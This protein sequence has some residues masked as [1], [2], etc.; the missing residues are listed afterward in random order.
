MRRLVAAAL[1][2]LL[3]VSASG[4]GAPTGP[5]PA[6]LADDA[7]VAPAP[8]EL[9][10]WDVPWDDTRPR[11]PYVAPDGRVWFVGQ[12]GDYVGVLAPSNGEF[13]RYDLD[14]GTG[15]HNLIVDDDGIVWY[16][17]NRDA[18]IGRLDPATG[19]IEKIETPVRDPHTLTFAPDGN[20]WFTAQGA[21]H[22]GHLDTGTREVRT[23]EVPTSGAR[24]YGILV[25]PDGRPWIVQLGTD[26]LGTVDPG[27]FEYAEIEL[28][29]DDARPRR[30]GRTSDG[31]IWYVDYARG[32]LGAYTPGAGD[33][34][35]GDFEEWRSP[36]G[37][38]ARPYAMAVDGNDRV[39]FVETGVSP[40][41]FVGFD[42]STGE[43]FDRAAVPSGGGTVRH[44]YYHAPE[45]VIWF[46]ADTNTVGRARLP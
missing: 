27:T 34:T 15:P 23:V 22:V 14:E 42:P 35:A 1:A 25:D 33:P 10:E 20:I 8:V 40:N 41:M 46:G 9:E 11:D 38:E 37:D 17:G 36:A 2:P 3:I 13:R 29:R 31:R 32:Y 19:E 44:M 45:D 6:D 18:H 30:I 4:S 21:N 7:A 26:K 12:R 28:P 39:W 24:P 43:F 5:A 16:A